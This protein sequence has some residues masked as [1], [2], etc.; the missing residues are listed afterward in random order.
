MYTEAGNARPGPGADDL[1]KSIRIL[2]MHLAKKGFQCTS[3]GST[4]G[5]Y[6]TAP[7]LDLCQAL[8][9]PFSHWL[10]FQPVLPSM[11]SYPH[12]LGVS[13]SARGRDRMALI[14]AKSLLRNSRI[15]RR[16]AGKCSTALGE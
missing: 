15:F 6:L 14:D 16:V 12:N 1:G 9:D 8:S 3:T 2:H 5:I 4:A 7:A 11:V 10:I 13:L